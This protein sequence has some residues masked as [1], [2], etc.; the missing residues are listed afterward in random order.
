LRE[1]FCVEIQT[2][3]TRLLETLTTM[4]LPEPIYEALPYLYI[5]VGATFLSGAI[6]IGIGHMA[7]PYY[8]GLGILSVLAGIVIHLRRAAARKGKP[9]T[10]LSESR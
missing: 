2:A 5:A 7:T 3:R 4:W 9:G 1:A 8:F 10:N 6:Y